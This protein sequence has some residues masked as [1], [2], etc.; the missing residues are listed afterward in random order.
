MFFNTYT[1]FPCCFCEPS[2]CLV[3][4]LYRVAVARCPLWGP[5]ANIL[6]GSG[7]QA[8]LLERTSQ[9]WNPRPWS[10][11]L[12]PP[13][14]FLATRHC[15][16]AVALPLPVRPAA[17]PNK[18]RCFPQGPTAEATRSLRKCANPLD[19]RS[20]SGGRAPARRWSHAATARPQCDRSQD[21]R[22][23]SLASTTS[24]VVNA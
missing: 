9:L 23:R 6:K 1:P 19:L 7:H 4:L 13:G 10:S 12:A 22:H 3:V 5:R 21:K 24:S 8:H 20:R 18:W 15:A 14:V 2:L 16:R 17:F 11:S